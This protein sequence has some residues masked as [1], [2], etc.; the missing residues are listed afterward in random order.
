MY[1][2]LIGDVQRQRAVLERSA[3]E[4]SA[5][6]ERSRLR[7]PQPEAVG[8]VAGVDDVDG[9]RRGA[10]GAGRGLDRDAHRITAALLRHTLVIDRLDEPASNKCLCDKK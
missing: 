2:L 7:R 3:E 9:R 1:L 4:R 8:A 6:D 10:A 5:D